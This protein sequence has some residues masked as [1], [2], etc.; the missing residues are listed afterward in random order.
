GTFD[1]WDPHWI[2]SEPSLKVQYRLTVTGVEV[3][4]VNLIAAVP[5]PDAPLFEITVVP[6][7]GPGPNTET[8][9]I[10]SRS[11]SAARWPTGI[12]TD[13]PTAGMAKSSSLHIGRRFG[14]AAP[15][16]FAA[17]STA[18]AATATRPVAAATRQRRIHCE[19]PTM[20][21]PTTRTNSD[22][23]QR[24][25]AGSPHPGWNPKSSMKIAT[26]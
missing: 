26:G 25:H 6:T 24:D 4:S 22:A 16:S 3:R 17:V 1:A 14:V 8:S 20:T 2:S 19:N 7:L 21:T 10:G 15:A 12:N 11:G 13:W 9:V 23:A 18:A 5:G